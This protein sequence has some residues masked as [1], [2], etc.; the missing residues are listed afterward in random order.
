MEAEYLNFEYE[1]SDLELKL[2]QVE[3]KM[4][5][6]NNEINRRSSD[7][8]TIRF[9]KNCLLQMEIKRLASVEDMDF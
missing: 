6:I 1:K 2:A 3:A 4:D 9:I 7:G 8:V 5:I